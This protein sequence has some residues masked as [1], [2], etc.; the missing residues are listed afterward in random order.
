M[1]NTKY[2]RILRNWYC[3]VVLIAIYAGLPNSAIGGESTE[4][5]LTASPLAGKA[6][7]YTYVQNVSINRH[8]QAV[9]TDQFR[10]LVFGNGECTYAGLGGK[11]KGRTE[12]V[13]CGQKEI[14]PGIYFV[15]WLELYNRVGS[16]AI[17]TNAKTVNASFFESTPTGLVNLAYLHAE[18]NDF[19]SSEEIKALRS[20][21]QE[22]LIRKWDSERAKR[23]E[24]TVD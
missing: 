19:G 2:T 12:T 17:N 23:G 7:R 13:A 1:A 14:A 22:A 5:G 16:M 6:M 3:F 9:A 8:F 20:E 4:V 11:M 24:K 18:I 15:T 21:E 10:E